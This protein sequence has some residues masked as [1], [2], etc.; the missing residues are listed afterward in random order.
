MEKSKQL[1]KNPR[2]RAA[3]VIVVVLAT[4]GIFGYY[5]TRHP[6][7]IS[8]LLSLPPSLLAL[9]AAGYLITIAANAYVLHASLKLIGHRVSYSDNVLLTSYSSIINFFGPLQ[10]GPGARAAYLK[11]KYGV[12]LRDFFGT[13]LLFYGFFA[14]INVCI[15]GVAAMWRYPSLLTVGVVALVGLCGMVAFFTLRARSKRFGRALHSL[16]LSDSNVWRI[17]I[18]ALSLSL[19]TA[20]IY[21]VE[22]HHIAPHISLWQAL[23]YAAAA[24]LSLFVSLTP[25]AIG[26]RESFLVIS[27][28]LHGID[29]STIL[30]ANIIDRAFYIVFLAVLFVA[31]LVV[32][33]AYKLSF[34]SHSRK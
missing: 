3:I 16:K 32:S 15:L 13:T 24:N 4:F 23:I 25:G 6:E 31:L 18:G 19:A 2:V 14:V 9:L 28:K 5:L 20:G 11:A 8:T 21:F 1:L 29:V 30:S 27:E 17:A 12:R 22:L 26:F 7:V 33:R 10:S 34:F